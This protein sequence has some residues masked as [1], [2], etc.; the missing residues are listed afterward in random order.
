M[1]VESPIDPQFTAAPA[2]H[3]PAPAKPE[4]SRK[5]MAL[6]NVLLVVSIA[7]NLLC[8]VA[9]YT[10]ASRGAIFGEYYTDIASANLSVF[11]WIVAGIVLAGLGTT[12]LAYFMSLDFRRRQRPKKRIH[13][14]WTAFAVHLAGWALGALGVA[15]DGVFAFLGAAVVVVLVPFI[16]PLLERAI[17][18][19]S[20][21]SADSLLRAHAHAAARGAAHTGLLFKPADPHA[22]EIYGLALART[23][24][25]EASLAYLLG[26]AGTTDISSRSPHIV[27]ALADVYEQAG[28]TERAIEALE[29]LQRTEPSYETFKRLANN[30]LAAGRKQQAMQEIQALPPAQ[31]REWYDI[32]RELV[33]ELGVADDQR[34][35]CREV[36]AGEG[37]PYTKA[38][39]CYTQLLERHPGD[40]PTLLALVEISR[41][42]GDIDHAAQLVEQITNLDP[43]NTWDER[44][45]L[46]AYYWKK[47]DRASVLR[48]LNRLLLGGQATLEE[49]L[50]VLEEHYAE[51]DYARV[52]ELVKGDP[53]LSQDA[54]ALTTLAYCL[55]EGGRMAE[56][57]EQIARARAVS[58]E[59]GVASDLDALDKTIRTKLRAQELQQLA[60][61]ARKDPSNLDARFAY[62]DRLVPSGGADRVVVELEDLLRREPDLRQDVEREIRQLLNRH[63]RNF[64]L[65]DYLGDLYLRDAAY[66]RAFDLY[67]E[68]V[69]GELNADALLHDA[70]V[71]ILAQEPRHKPSLLAEVNYSFQ[72]GTAQDALAMLDR[73]Y[74][75]GGEAN[76]GL[77]IME[78]DAAL[79]ME[80][81][82][83]AERAGAA[84][85]HDHPNDPEL[86]SRMAEIASR[87]GKFDLALQ[88][89]QA[90]AQAEPDNV[91]YR[92]LI[93]DMEEKR[94]RA[95]IAEIQALIAKGENTPELRE[96]LGDLFHDFGQLN[97]AIAEYQRS[98]LNNPD[99]RIAR[100]KL[101]YVLARK[102][103]YLEADEALRDADLRSDLPE[104]QQ[105][106]L[107]ALFYSSGQMMEDDGQDERALDLYRKIFRVDAAYKD[108]VSHI[109][110]LQRTDKKKR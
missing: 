17:G 70:A 13:L 52:E 15:P 109:E 77:R 61:L 73:Y 25:A 37:P 33:F 95:R 40:L 23:G 21:R 26:G 83:R 43:E 60:E 58:P 11:V 75:T 39:A 107:K 97:E 44:R 1:S 42:R 29:I 48:H 19:A 108:V 38:A 55:H 76:A 89:L 98:G 63:G 103:M 104:D 12:L 5:R 88:R 3:V 22:E 35:F 30:W 84:V 10:I 79:S 96:E 20:I 91:Q 68:K 67:H 90:A 2:K 101:G 80:D 100:A 41:R 62:Y 74:A 49:K 102:G 16:I 7:V 47:G 27:R 56:A 34:S 50:R 36:E 54:K 71:K 69:Q 85:L 99:R 24:K 86:L 57:S 9:S 78:L 6:F 14:L 51:G 66:D 31:R 18:A 65:L 28:Q 46:V 4:P 32:L 105:N 87:R 72:N 110:R 8:A 59:G 92:R 106:S 81:M 94:K 64:R 82:E 93:R 53:D 45:N